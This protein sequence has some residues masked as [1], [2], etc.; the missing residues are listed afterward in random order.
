LN[1]IRGFL[2][3]TWYFHN[4]FNNYGQIEEHVTK[5]LENETFSWTQE[6]TKDFEN[7]KQAMCMHH[8]LAMPNFTK[9]LIV[10]Y[11]SLGHDIGVGLIQEGKPLSFESI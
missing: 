9:T 5:L 11:D 1:N 6:E 10:E 8:V 3:L 4:F 7:L 2:L